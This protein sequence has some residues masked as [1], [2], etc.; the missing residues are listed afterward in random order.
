[1]PEDR[2]R[3]SDQDIGEIRGIV[4]MLRETVLDNRAAQDRRHLEN[5]AR[6]DAIVGL[7]PKVE[8]HG[9]WIDEEG[10]PTVETVKRAKWTLGGIALASGGIGAVITKIL[11]GTLF[12]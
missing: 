11:G 6:L 5:I 2:R 9:A 3:S 8:A 1:M 12:H 10:K 4:T 7:M